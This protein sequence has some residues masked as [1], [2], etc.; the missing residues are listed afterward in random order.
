ME[1]VRTSISLFPPQEALFHRVKSADRLNKIIRG[2]LP[3]LQNRLA[4]SK[5]VTIG[6][7]RDS[8]PERAGVVPVSFDEDVYLE[9][10]ML[11]AGSRVSVSQMIAWILTMYF[12]NNS[13]VNYQRSSTIDLAFSRVLK[14]NFD[15]QAVARLRTGLN[16]RLMVDI[17]RIC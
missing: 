6:Y 4:K 7:Q 8:N 15:Y 13:Q 16:Q 9:L 12:E 10:G 3:R 5:W 11:R 14:G 2:Y 1:S 17:R